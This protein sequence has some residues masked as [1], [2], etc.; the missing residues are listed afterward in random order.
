VADAGR[1]GTSQRTS[2]APP[3]SSRRSR[4]ATQVS[5]VGAVSSKPVPVKKLKA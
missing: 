5:A 3:S 1:I 2:T 4:A